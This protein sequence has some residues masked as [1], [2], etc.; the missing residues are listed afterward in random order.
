MLLLVSR[1]N[2][3]GEELFMSVLRFG[4]MGLGRIANKFVE[5]VQNH[6]PGATVTAVASS[7]A[8]RAL[9]FAEKYGIDRHYGSYKNLADDA[10]VDIVYVATTNEIHH[11]CCLYSIESGKHLLCEKPLVLTGEQAR[12][13]RDKAAAK[14]VFLMEAMWSKFLPATIKAVEWA[15]QG[16]IGRLRGVSASFCLSRERQQS[17]KQF[18]LERGGGAMYDIGIY[19]L[20]LN[21]MLSQERKITDVKA[22]RLQATTGVDL[23]DYV[24][25]LHDDEFVADLKCHLG[26]Y[27]HNEAY[28]MGMDGYIRFAPFFNHAQRIELFTTA[29][30]S[31][32]YAKQPDDVFEHEAPSGFEYEIEHVMDCIN[33]GL[34]ESP[35]HSLSDSIEL[36]E[37]MD[38]IRAI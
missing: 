20:A 11:K 25:I 18:S 10:A 19:G 9:A 29:P 32:E 8:D 14:K 21:Q 4:I 15:K 23:A 26:C 5:T 17:P 31:S 33:K 22:I 13:L 24:L 6:V 7:C 35:V 3:I 16:R 12:D 34:I 30:T 27:T 28:I 1:I 2:N 36:A 38:R 37:L